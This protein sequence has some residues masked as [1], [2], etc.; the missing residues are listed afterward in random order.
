MARA[1]RRWRLL[2]GWALTLGI[3]IYA[4]VGSGSADEPKLAATTDETEDASTL[5]I[6]G[7]SDGEVSPGDAVIIKFTGAT[8]DAPLEAKVAKRPAQIIVREDTSVVVRIPSDVPTGKASLR[9]H[10]GTRKSKAWDLHIRTSNHKKLIARLLG[11]LALFVFGLGLLAL[12]L[13]GL[14]GHRLRAWLSRLT[15][16]PARGIA[17]GA[18]VGTGTQLTSSSAAFTVS[19]VDARMLRVTPAIAVLVGAQLGASITGA[20][21][22]VQLSS[23][24]LL[25][26]AIGVVWSRLAQTRR[27]SAIANVV[28]GAGL[29]LYG[30]HLLQTSVEPLVSDPTILPYVEYLRSAGALSLVRCA[31]IGALLAFVLQGPGPVYVLVVGLA[32][33]TTTL[34]LANALAILAG[35][36]LG[37]GLAMSMIAWQAGPTMRPLARAHLWFAIAATLMTV[38]MVPLTASLATRLVPDAVVYGHSVLRTRVAAQLSV[39]FISGE[40]VAG[41]LWLAAIPRVTRFAS[42]VRERAIEE[43]TGTRSDA[44][45]ANA[46]VQLRS[47]LTSALE[48]STTGDRARATAAELALTES[49][50]LLEERYRRSGAQITDERDVRA[51]VAG[52]QLH[53]AVEQAVHVAELCVERGVRISEEAQERLAAM[54]TLAGES[55]DELLAALAEQRSPDLEEAGAREIRI[56]ALE[57]EGRKATVIRSR[58]RGDSTSSLNIGVAE[59]IDT[60]EN[61]GNHLFRVAK[62]L[63]DDPDQP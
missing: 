52:L 60:F 50:T 38:A 51:L 63:L 21:I 7:I 10:Q 45:L 46:L 57:A 34:P 6:T 36:N 19:L 4:I 27:G 62:A 59:L 5:R 16:S 9:L 17:I 31:M 53:R 24:S 32:Q 3:A 23:E 22:P 25:V 41:V 42:R 28:L 58:R 11:G 2:L 18:L 48:M 56:N 39:A 8:S 37:A 15:E 12:G 30:L 1:R 13:R 44:E 49:R 47:A 33:T 43:A 35:T 55:F 54:H 40:I 61:V 20:L 29:M 26:I 14:A